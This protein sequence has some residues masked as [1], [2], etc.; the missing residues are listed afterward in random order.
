MNS[1]IIFDLKLQTKIGQML[2]N[3]DGFGTKEEFQTD[4]D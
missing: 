3:P 1:G 2:C 4:A